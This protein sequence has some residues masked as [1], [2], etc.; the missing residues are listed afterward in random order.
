MKT[1]R[2]DSS[3][4]WVEI[5]DFKLTE[6]Q[7]NLLNSN[8]EKDLIKKNE[9]IAL[10]DSKTKFTPIEKDLILLNSV[11]EHFKPKIEATDIYECISFDY[12]LNQKKSS[13]IFNYRV[14]NEHK[15]IRF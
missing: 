4:N 5:K 1:F 14:N 8:D 11:Y 7:S 2:L 10:I 15:Q 9:L 13:G 3:E 12:V 6:V